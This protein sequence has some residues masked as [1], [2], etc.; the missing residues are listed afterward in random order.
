MAEWTLQ[1]GGIGVGVEEHPRAGL[2]PG[3]VAL[4][5]S[6]CARCSRRRSTTVRRS[7]AGKQ[8]GGGCGR[9]KGRLSGVGAGR[10]LP[11]LQLGLRC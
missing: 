11:P 6:A 3:P 8:R 10:S 2:V 9:H 5:S 1:M 7:E 4:V